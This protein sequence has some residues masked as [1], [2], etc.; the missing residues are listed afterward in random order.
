MSRL[1]KRLKS[2]TVMILSNILKD[3]RQHKEN[4]NIFDDSLLF[5]IYSVRF[6]VCILFILIYHFCTNLFRGGMIVRVRGRHVPRHDQQP[7]GRELTRRSDPSDLVVGSAHMSP[8]GQMLVFVEYIVD[9]IVN[10]GIRWSHVVMLPQ[11]C[12]NR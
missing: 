11:R 10:L 7:R 8:H 4:S 6:F 12:N 1:P 9:I 3:K 2:T 5:C